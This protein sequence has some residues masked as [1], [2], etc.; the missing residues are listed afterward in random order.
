[1]P[2]RVLWFRRDL[3]L[4]DHPAL[5]EAAEA[6][7]VVGLFVLDPRLRAPSGSP[8]LAFLA[9]CLRDLNERM[10]GALVIRTGYPEQ[11]VPAVAGE[12]AAEAVH[13]SADFGVYGRE[14]D[15]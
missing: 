14:R 4:V 15:A 2:T 5:N 1:M 12:V 6:A 13:I 8:R 7:D 3:R 9:G 11:V 10:G